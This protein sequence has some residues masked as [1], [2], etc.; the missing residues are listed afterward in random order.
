MDTCK[1]GEYG[2]SQVANNSLTFCNT[3]PNLPSNITVGQTIN[4]KNI[5]CLDKIGSGSSKR[6]QFA[7]RYRQVFTERCQILTLMIIR[8]LLLTTHP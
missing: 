8:G 1:V 7:T 6:E 4:D 3:N 2:A 5:F